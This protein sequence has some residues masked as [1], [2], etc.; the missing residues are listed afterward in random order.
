MATKNEFDTFIA[1]SKILTDRQDLDVEI[2]AQYLNR[3]QTQYPK[4]VQDVLK[5]FGTIAKEIKPEY[6]TF[7]VKRRLVEGEKFSP[8]IQNI[9]RVWYSGGFIVLDEK[10]DQE[11]RNRAQY[12]Y[13]LIWKTAKT[14]APADS[15]EP[16]GHWAEAP[17]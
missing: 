5:E 4:E 9:L 13:G 3:L 7:E 11:L 8:I 10:T 1:L 15:H 12:N 2:A 6:L 14:H 17:N 16:Y